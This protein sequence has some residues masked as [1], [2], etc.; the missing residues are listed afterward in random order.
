MAAL[1]AEPTNS[2]DDVTPR[3][4]SRIFHLLSQL[5]Q[6]FHELNLVGADDLATHERRMSDPDCQYWLAE[7]QGSPAGHVILRGIQSVDR[8]WS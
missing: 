8:A 7:Q 5:E 6:R 4:R 3:G 2:Q 1:S